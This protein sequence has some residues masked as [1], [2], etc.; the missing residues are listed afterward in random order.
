[1]RERAASTS[2]AG[3][4][5]MLYRDAM[6]W[7]TGVCEGFDESVTSKFVRDMGYQYKW[8]RLDVHRTMLADEVRVN[9]FRRAI[10]DVVKEGDAVLDLGTGTGVLAFFAA[11]AGARKVYAVDSASV[12]ELAKKVAAKNRF[13][14]IEFIRG[15]IRDLSVPKV[16]CVIAELIGPYVIEEGFTEK[17]AKAKGFLKPGGKIIPSRIDVYVAPV[18]SRDTGV[19]FWDRLYGVDYTPIESDARELRQFTATDKT[20]RLAPDALAFSIDS[21]NPPLKKMVFARDFTVESDGVFHGLLM[22]FVA[23]LSEKISLSTSP[24]SPRTHW[25][26]AFLPDGGRLKVKKGDKISVKLSTKDGNKG[27]DWKY[28]VVGF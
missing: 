16:D 6:M 8:M 2:A 14:N 7:L 22:H 13:E 21:Y 27:W 23:R 10:S 25:Q 17:I 15:D 12:I 20:R 18:E 28:N 3:K 19:G 4:A 9:A 24:E 26:Q 11:Q 1:M 5:R